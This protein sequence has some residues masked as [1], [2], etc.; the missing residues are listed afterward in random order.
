MERVTTQTHTMKWT[1][2]IQILF[3]QCGLNTGFSLVNQLTT[4]TISAATFHAA[5]G[6]KSLHYTG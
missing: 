5:L 1:E 6:V 4:G 3:I 2:E